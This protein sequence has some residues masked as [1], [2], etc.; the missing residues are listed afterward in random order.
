M[1]GRPKRLSP[2]SQRLL[3]DR[4][5]A[6]HFVD[7]PLASGERLAPMRRDHFHPKRRFAHPHDSGAMDQSNRFDHRPSFAHAL[8]QQPELV[9]RHFLERLVV[10]RVDRRF[11][12]VAANDSREADG[13]SHSPGRPPPGYQR[14]FIDGIGRDDEMGGHVRRHH[15][16]EAVQGIRPD[17]LGD[18]FPA[19]GIVAAS[20][21]MFPS[22]FFHHCPRCAAKAAGRPGVEIF[23]CAECGFRLYFNPAVS[24]AAFIERPDGKVLM[25][26]RAKEPALGKLA[27]PGGF[28]DFGETAEDSLKREVKEEAGIQIRNV[29]YLASHPNRYPYRDVTYRILDLFFVAEAVASEHAKPLD[30]VSEILWVDPAELRPEDMAFPS[31]SEALRAYQAGRPP[32][33]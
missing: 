26:R 19:F 1:I 13:R 28:V 27:P 29:R 9:L 32:K 22:D 2:G 5:R 4:N 14:G 23:N 3:P 12:F 6:L 8:E 18:K 31:M 25:V 15:V 16:G 17:F 7:Q 11:A 21:T 33:S 10:D 20:E 24:A 30:D